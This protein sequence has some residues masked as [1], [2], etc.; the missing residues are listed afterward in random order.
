MIR[1][2]NDQVLIKVDVAEERSAGGLYLPT[3]EPVVKNTG[4]VEAVGDS[5]VIGVV[6]GDHVFFEKGMGRRFEI[7]RVSYCVI[8]Y[9]DIIAVL[10][11]E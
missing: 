7:D 9:Y 6:P 4:V 1:P 5:A 10:Q 2:I 3:A 8:S 11:D